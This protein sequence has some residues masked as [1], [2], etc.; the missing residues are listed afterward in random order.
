VLSVTAVQEALSRHLSKLDNLI[1]V[2]ESAIEQVDYDPLR[3]CVVIAELS[4]SRTH[5]LISVVLRWH[6]LPPELE[7]S[8]TLAQK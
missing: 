1:D 3:L 7:P 4:Q 2:V 8:T 6:A 5:D